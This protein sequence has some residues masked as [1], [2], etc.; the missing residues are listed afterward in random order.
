MDKNNKYDYDVA[1]M[2]S[3]GQIKRGQM[4]D[5]ELTEKGYTI[6]RLAREG[7]VVAVMDDESFYISNPINI[8]SL[9]IRGKFMGADTSIFKDYAV[10]ANRQISKDGKD[11]K[12]GNKKI[13]RKDIDMIG[14]EHKKVYGIL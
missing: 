10:K 5:I 9:H 12:M 11:W 6:V 7:N 14:V 8:N 3:V 1:D 2:I 4:V 13:T